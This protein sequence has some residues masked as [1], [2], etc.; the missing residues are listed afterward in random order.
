MNCSCPRLEIGP[1]VSIIQHTPDCSKNKNKP[2]F[3]VKKYRL[4]AGPS[5]HISRELRVISEIEG[6]VGEHPDW[7]AS[8][9]FVPEEGSNFQAIKGPG[10]WLS[11]Q[12]RLLPQLT[13]ASQEKVDKVFQQ[14]DLCELCHLRPVRRKPDGRYPTLRACQ[15]C[16][17]AR[18]KQQMKEGG[19]RHRREKRGVKICPR[20]KIGVVELWKK[21]CGACL[22]KSKAEHRFKE[23]EYFRRYHQKQMEEKRGLGEIAEPSLEE[24]TRALEIGL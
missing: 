5:E 19:L 16:A 17:A 9:Q 12:R 20:C 22:E 2:A 10:A 21:I 24:P 23:K 3:G 8:H 11:E 14:I 7:K 18:L 15:E 6:E 1:L 4:T 13:G